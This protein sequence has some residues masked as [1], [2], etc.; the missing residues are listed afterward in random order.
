MITIIDML[1]QI[2]SYLIPTTA[3]RVTEQQQI[4]N[5]HA[6]AHNNYLNQNPEES[7]VRNKT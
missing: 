1:H 2:P 7:D 4:F 5:Y 6:V 3:F